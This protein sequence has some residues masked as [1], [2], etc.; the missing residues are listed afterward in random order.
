MVRQAWLN[1]WIARH[2][3]RGL[4]KAPHVLVVHDGEHECVD[5]EV[6]GP[7]SKWSVGSSWSP[8]GK[9]GDRI[10]A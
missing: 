5:E 6:D 2:G 8:V 3:V 9:K 10:Y 7:K 4:S 1:A